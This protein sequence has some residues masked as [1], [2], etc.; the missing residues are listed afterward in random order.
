MLKFTSKL[1]NN[2]YKVKVANKTQEIGLANVGIDK[3]VKVATI[4]QINI[5]P[6]YQ[7]KKYG[8]S[9]LAYIENEMKTNYHINKINVIAYQE[10]LDQVT[11]FYQKNGYS[12][13]DHIT[14]LNS[15]YDN[16]EIQYDL[17]SMVK[18]I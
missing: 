5:V 9:L 17:V 16:D 14:G 4:Y 8:S 18:K 13:I 6:L 12:T 1:V 2:L 7:G 15:I 3:G 10:P 11:K